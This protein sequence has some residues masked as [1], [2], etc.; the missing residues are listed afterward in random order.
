MLAVYPVN[1]KT[2][3]LLPLTEKVWTKLGPNAA[4]NLMVIASPDVAGEAQAFVEHIK[5]LF[6]SADVVVMHK[7]VEDDGPGRNK[8]FKDSA[9]WVS[10]REN[11]E[12]WVYLEDAVPTQ[13]G[14]LNT[15]QEEYNIFGK[16]FL[17]AVEKTYFYKRDED[18]G[19]DVDQFRQSGEHMRCGVFPPTFFTTST[20]FDYLN[21]PH[22]MALQ[23]EIVPYCHRS[24]K[25]ATMWAS[26]EFH[27]DDED[28][29][30]VGKKDGESKI[31]EVNGV[32]IDSI[33]LLHGCKDESLLTLVLEKK[34]AGPKEPITDRKY[35]A[36]MAK[37]A[38]REA[39]LEAQIANIRGSYQERIDELTEELKNIKA[40]A[41]KKKAAPRKRPAQSKKKA[42]SKV[43]K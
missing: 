41:P 16:P 27:M 23:N 21:Q 29:C 32:N 26:K 33:A 30:V 36:D 35:N 19:K 8:M 12:P 15:I 7:N 13:R 18:T 34:I 25:I 22:A 43:A 14:W 40:V 20:L 39:D 3:S 28:C 42:R 24:E 37:A 5:N 2:A 9:Q 1:I 31:R 17:G 4:H 38:E 6:A 10:A 11:P